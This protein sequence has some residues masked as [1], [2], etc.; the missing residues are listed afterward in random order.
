MT[1]YQ[2]EG[3]KPVIGKNSY[4][5]RSAEVVGDVYI[6]ENCYIGPGAKIRGDYGSI[7]IGNHTSVQENCVL[8][9][10]P[11]LSTVIGDNV[12]IGHGAI[13]HG[14]I[15]HNFVI[16]GIGAIVADHAEINDWCLI[17][18]GALVTSNTIIERESLVVGVPAKTIRK[19]TDENREL[20][21]F[22]ANLYSKLAP[23]YLNDLKEIKY[24]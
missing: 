11:N 5:A 10:G 21:S 20:I 13:V 1:L 14:P 23:R 19:I 7:R 8:H 9:A 18:A 22:S 3:R 12:T 24:A 2:F 15:I 4:I 6:G 17:A 16:V